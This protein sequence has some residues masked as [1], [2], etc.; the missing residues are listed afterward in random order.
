MVISYPALAQVLCMW[1]SEGRLVPVSNCFVLSW[2]KI[3]LKSGLNSCA[4][5]GIV[6][7]YKKK[8]SLSEKEIMAPKVAWVKRKLLI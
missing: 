6:V 1:F 7:N 2:Y 3:K 4:K 8:D 5:G